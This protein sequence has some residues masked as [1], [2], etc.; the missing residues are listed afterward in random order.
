MS[1]SGTRIV[2][3][4]AISPAARAGLRS[5]DI[6]ISCNGVKVRDWVD[7]LTVSTDSEILLSIKRGPLRRQVKLKTRPGVQWGIELD[8]STIRECSNNCVFC[9][10]D[11]Q[12]PGLRASLTVKDDDVRFSFL[13]GTYISLTSSQTREAISRGFSS[14]HV[15]VQTTD[16]VLRGKLLGLPVPLKILPNIDRLAEANIDIQAQI[17]EVPG[18]NDGIELEKTLADLY[19][20]SNVSIIGIVP[21][22]LTRWRSNLT[23]LY[24][25]T[26]EQA[27]TTLQIIQKWQSRALLE[28]GYGW[29]YPA[30]EYYSITGVD[31]PD[32]DFYK[33]KSLL[34]NGIGLLSNMIS[35]CTDRKFNGNGMVF[36][37]TMAA[38]Y[39]KKILQ[40]TKYDVVPVVNTLMGPDVTVTGLLSGA[41]II[42][43]IK[44]HT[45]SQ[46][47][48][49]FL[50]SVM[51]NH[52]D[53]TL[54]EFSIEDISNITK[55]QVV[56]LS[57]IRDLP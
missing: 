4:K 2:N 5:G 45:I 18:W 44:K 28:K 53:V 17:V 14:L 38:P 30:D 12:P 47:K 10:V 35:E 33:E 52:N 15:S 24:K 8:G 49:V 3:V 23:P 16:P 43:S 46:T 31:L 19:Q 7:L 9:F 27:C 6:L 57:S 51:F 13:E 37:G 54:D 20:R 11:Q 55:K 40:N 50:S 56:S 25:H 36:T 34:A 21:V 48:M 42:E 32:V 22:G 26:K 39:I 1:A 29:V 41:D